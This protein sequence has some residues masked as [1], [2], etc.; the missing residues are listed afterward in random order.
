MHLGYT[1]HAM[2]R[3][4]ER[5]IAPHYAEVAIACGRRWYVEEGRY[6]Y[7]WQGFCFIVDDGLVITAY[8]MREGGA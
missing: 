3:M 1:D 7:E 2:Q 8:D 5:N 4:R 6:G